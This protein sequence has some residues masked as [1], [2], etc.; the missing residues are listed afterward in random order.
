MKILFDSQIFDFQKY[1]G[2]SSYFIQ[3]MLELEKKEINFKLAVKSTFNENFSN[4]SEINNKKQLNVFGLRRLQF[5]RIKKTNRKLLIDEYKASKKIIYHS[6]F[7]FDYLNGIKIL[8]PEVITI[9]DMIHEEYPQYFS[10]AKNIIEIK[11]RKIENCQHIICVSNFTKDKLLEFYPNISNEKL[12][13]IHHGFD[14]EPVKKVK[15]K[16]VLLYMGNRGQYKGFIEFLKL[17]VNWLKSNQTYQVWCWG[18]GNF[19]KYEKT[20]FS[21]LGLLSQLK[22]LD[23]NFYSKKYVLENASML[24]LTSFIEGFGLPIIEALHYNCPVVAR[25]IP[26]F[27]EVGKEYALFFQNQES[28]ENNFNIVI[29]Q[30]ISKKYESLTLLKNYYGRKR[31]VNQTIEVYKKLL[32]A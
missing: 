30:D 1:G 12:S 14:I 4:Y 6:T 26:V 15:R 9:H 8:H 31:M 28:L 18:S 10:N 5:E 7:Y 22:Y 21:Q 11:R 19:S 25:N 27:C 3:L 29:N 17:A 24:I 16:E 23:P 32:Q 13:V 2:I 20:I